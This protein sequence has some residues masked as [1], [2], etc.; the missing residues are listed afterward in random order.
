MEDVEI[1][2]V[3]VRHGFP[4]PKYGRMLDLIRSVPQYR[5]L[6]ARIQQTA[7]ELGPGFSLADLRTSCTEA[8]IKA[9]VLAL[10]DKN[11]GIQD[12]HPVMG[13]PPP[14][15]TVYGMFGSGVNIVDVGSGNCMKIRRYT[16]SL[17]I[18]AVDPNLLNES[19]HVIKEVKLSLAD[20][21]KPDPGQDLLFTSWM[22]MTQLSL[23]EEELLRA[24]DGL[25]LVPDHELLVSQGIATRSGDSV[26]VR[27]FKGVYTDRFVSMRG[28]AV[29]PGYILAPTFRKRDVEVVLGP[30]VAGSYIPQIDAKPAGFYDL[31]FTDITPKFD[32]VPY[33]LECDGGKAQL[34]GRNGDTNEG[35][36]SFD[37]HLCLH[38]EELEGC[39]VLFRIVY[40]RGM[41]PP[42]HGSV[43]R[44]FCERV[45]VRING[46]PVLGPP[47]WRGGEINTGVLLHWMDG[48]GHKVFKVPVDGV[49]TRVDG[50][51]FYCKY[52]W[53]VDLK[54]A[55][56]AKVKKKLEDAGYTLKVV[57]EWF[58]GINELSLVRDGAAVTMR[59]LKPRRDKNRT[60]PVDTVLY[61]VDRPTLGESS[62]LNDAYILV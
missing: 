11:R 59:P 4:N 42:H 51:D 19:K 3:P 50:S 58:E 54:H 8:G 31:N 33:E 39:Y 24:S 20:F 34:T 6:A 15:N 7:R 45:N 25:H 28:V 44:A 55:D 53:T 10:V 46:K 30:A 35:V 47:P 1:S 22:S 60:T 40:Y 27:T 23:H 49:V 17:K 21:L 41:I 18:T 16:G 26:E 61:L 13:A 2:T 32:G 36:C 5:E 52:M 57:G 62:V 48:E 37:E 14:T 38:I 29:S 56:L 43:L 12:Q 9:Q